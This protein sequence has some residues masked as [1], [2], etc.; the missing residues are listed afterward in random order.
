MNNLRG[1]GISRMSFLFTKFHV[2]SCDTVTLCVTVYEY[3]VHVTASGQLQLTNDE[4]LSFLCLFSVG[5]CI[6]DDQLFLIKSY[7]QS[8]PKIFAKQDNWMTVAKPNNAAYLF[9]A[10]TQL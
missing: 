10:M 9:C 1:N 6:N 2:V 5:F 7:I 8:D 3:R 4:I